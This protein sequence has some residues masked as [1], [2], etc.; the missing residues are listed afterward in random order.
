MC[1]GTR[2]GFEWLRFWRQVVAGIMPGGCWLVAKMEA[3]EFLR[4]KVVYFF[5]SVNCAEFSAVR[6]GLWLP[7]NCQSEA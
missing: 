7:A 4:E 3:A 6:R 2:V 1:S 5:R